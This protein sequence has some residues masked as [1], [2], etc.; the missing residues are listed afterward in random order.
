LKRLQDQ[1]EIN[2]SNLNN[3]RREASRHF[4]KR[5]GEYLKDEIHELATNSNTN[6]IRELRRGIRE[7]KR[8][9]QLKNS[10]VSE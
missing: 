2:G 10:L 4:R 7:F 8:G 6:N 3:V 1:S 5:K 9:Y